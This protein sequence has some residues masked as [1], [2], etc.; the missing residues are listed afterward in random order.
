MSV[1][2]PVQIFGV[3]LINTWWGAGGSHASL[4]FFGD[5]GAYYS[6]L[7]QGNIAIR[8][9]ANPSDWLNSIIALATNAQKN[10]PT[11]K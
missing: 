6:K 7:L 11:V 3:T 2:I 1:D 10:E 9:M 5:D 8:N 4:K